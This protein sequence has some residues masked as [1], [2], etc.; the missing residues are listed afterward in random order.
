LRLSFPS[1]DPYWAPYLWTG[2]EYEP[3]VQ[4]I[5][6]KLAPMPNKIFVD[7]G[8]NIGYWTVKVSDPSLGFTEFIAVEANP[9]LIPLLQENIRLNRIEC[10]LFH[11][12]I[13]ERA[14]EIVHLGGTEHHASA[15]VG[16]SGVPVPTVSLTSLLHER[17]TAGRMIV[18]KL[19][20][21]GCE[22]A[23]MRG[24]AGLAD[25]DLVY[26]VE[27]WPRSGMLGT[28]FM[29][30]HGYGVIGVAPDGSAKELQSVGDA[31][32]FNSATTP[33]YQPSNVIGCRR[34]RTPL[35]LSLFA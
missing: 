24:A 34:E 21:E 12:A 35:L 15:S 33:R 1:F 9:A 28:A 6:R 4:A 10:D 29:L 30:E 11:A 2:K 19:D 8:A 22:I 18:V 23:A 14:G 16:A 31:I 7:C 25:Q 26:I 5:F 3:D 13:S 17:D 32:E 27:D 20:V